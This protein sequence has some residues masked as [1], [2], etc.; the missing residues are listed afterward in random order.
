MKSHVVSSTPATSAA[1]TASSAS[2]AAAAAAAATPAAPPT[3]PAS[4][5]RGRAARTKT[6]RGRQRKGGENFVMYALILQHYLFKGAASTTAIR[7]RGL[8]SPPQTTA[9]SD[10]N[11]CR[12]FMHTLRIAQC[13]ISYQFDQLY[14]H[15]QRIGIYD[16]KMFFRIISLYSTTPSPVR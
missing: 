5:G 2:A 7:V 11:Y 10:G 12:P 4:S 9:A 1:P 13:E 8:L 14:S 16:Y 15:K 6:A 3:A